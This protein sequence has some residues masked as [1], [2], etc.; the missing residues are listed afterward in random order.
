MYGKSVQNKQISTRHVWIR[1]TV[2]SV[3]VYFGVTC[4]AAHSVWHSDSTYSFLTNKSQTV[5]M[6]SNL[7]MT[8]GLAST[9]HLPSVNQ[10]SPCSTPTVIYH[11]VPSI[12]QQLSIVHQDG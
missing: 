1:L 3:S 8:Y 5:M 4:T 9:A 10:S 2:Q 12:L 11:S 7:G 6:D